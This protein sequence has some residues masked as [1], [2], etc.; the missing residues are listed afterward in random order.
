M[1]Y[2]EKYDLPEEIRSYY[3]SKEVFNLYIILLL[4][5]QRRKS[6]IAFYTMRPSDA[7]M[8]GWTVL[9]VKVSKFKENAEQIVV[10]KLEALHDI[11]AIFIETRQHP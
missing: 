9:F 7:Y 2:G 5:Q 1:P 10:C 8:L 6:G 4:L 11:M 3:S